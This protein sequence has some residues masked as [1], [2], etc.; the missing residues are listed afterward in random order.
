MFSLQLIGVLF[1]VLGMGYCGLKTAWKKEGAR[2]VVQ[3]VQKN[4]RKAQADGKEEYGELKEKIDELNENP[5]PT[6]FE[7]AE[8]RLNLEE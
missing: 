3:E 2:E 1:A 8:K 7:S 5:E 4:I 6:D